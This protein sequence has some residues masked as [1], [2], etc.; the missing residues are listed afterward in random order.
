MYRARPYQ[1]LIAPSVN[2]ERVESDSKTMLVRLAG[3]STAVSGNCVVSSGASNRLGTVAFLSAGGGGDFTMFVIM[4][5][6]GSLPCGVSEMGL[7][8]VWGVMV[9][10]P[11]YTPTMV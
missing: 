9:S 5:T 8:P 3:W 6:P 11:L 1:A 10:S 7:T 2:S 4:T